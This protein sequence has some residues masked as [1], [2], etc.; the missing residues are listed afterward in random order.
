MAIEESVQNAALIM[1]GF[2]EDQSQSLDRVEFA[3]AMAKYAKAAEVSLGELVDFMTVVSCMEEN[4]P[5]E[6]AFFKAISPQATAEI[7]EIEESLEA[8]G[9][10]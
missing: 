9:L 2:D 5:Q 4:S 7:K 3:K 6:K 8:L 10:E 1:I